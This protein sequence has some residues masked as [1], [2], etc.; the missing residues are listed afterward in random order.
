MTPGAIIA[1]IVQAGGE[2]WTEGDR[3]KFRSVPSRLVPAI[4]ET[5]AGLLALLNDYDREE[6]LAIHAESTTP[7]DRGREDVP[8]FERMGGEIPQPRRPACVL[9]RLWRRKWL[10]S[11]AV[12]APSSSRPLLHR[13]AELA[14]A[15]GRR[16]D[17]HPLP[18]VGMACATRTRRASFRLQE[19]PP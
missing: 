6:R 12:H 17:C 10:P 7:P 9:G 13:G 8:G 11:H 3:L 14:D 5:K 1:A 2:I 15:H 4:R 18:A 16:T 19:A